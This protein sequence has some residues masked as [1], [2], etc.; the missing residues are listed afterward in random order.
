MKKLIKNKKSIFSKGK[1]RNMNIENS[2]KLPVRVDKAL[3]WLEKSRDTWKEK[4][5]KAK[6]ELKK[7]TL[8]TKRARKQRDE[9]E[10]KLKEERK[11]QEELKQKEQEIKELKE[12]LEK[13]QQQIEILKK[14]SSRL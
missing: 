1:K 9:L 7:K 3:G 13:S 5:L 4:T 11:A 6:L 8:A 10:K 2:T 12:E 14:K